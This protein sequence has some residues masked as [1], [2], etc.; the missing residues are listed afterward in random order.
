MRGLDF[1]NTRG[2]SNETHLPAESVLAETC[3]RIQLESTNQKT[4]VSRMADLSKLGI[5]CGN[6]KINKEEKLGR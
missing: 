1:L 4:A 5:Q 2:V 3:I 6:F